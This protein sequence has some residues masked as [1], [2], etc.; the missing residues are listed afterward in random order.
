MSGPGVGAA[1]GQVWSS[2]TLDPAIV[3]PLAVVGGLYVVGARRL[4]RRLGEGRRSPGRAVPFWLG[5]GSL[6]VALTSPL[7]DLGE[8]LFFVHMLQHSIV[9]LV[10][11]PLLVLG[12]PGTTLSWGLPG[13][14]RRG[15]ARCLRWGPLLAVGR[16][17][18]APAV[19][20]LVHAAVLWVWHAPVLYEATLSSDAVHAAQHT[21]FTIGGWLFWSGVLPAHRGRAL[22]GLG[23]FYV[24]TTAVHASLLAALLTFAPVPLYPAY[25]GR[26][27]PWGISLLEDQQIGGL[28]MWVPG[29]I[30]YLVAGLLL[31]ARW[32]EQCR[33]RP[34]PE[35]TVRG[36]DAA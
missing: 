11:T 22:G 24:F 23:I 1:P 6:V 16:W 26:G 36:N 10:A 14:L 8:S 29:G 15:V 12:R 33:E 4:R 25:A 17:L 13:G 35:W 5:W 18:R 7:H 27:V 21:S 30:I 31:F 3:V 28:V 32:L 34:A 9:L 20:W 19:A 2:W